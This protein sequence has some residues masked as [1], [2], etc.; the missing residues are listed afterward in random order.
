[1]RSVKRILAVYL[2]FA[3]AFQLFAPTT[4]AL[5]EELNV[6]SGATAQQP[7]GSEGADGSGGG[8]SADAGAASGDDASASDDVSAG[9]S[10][11]ASDDAASGDAAAGDAS[12]SQEPAA[13]E[14]A[15]AGDDAAD[16][17][18]APAMVAAG[19]TIATVD[20]LRAAMGKHGDVTATGGTV[21]A[22]TFNDAVGLRIISN[23]DPQLYQTAALTKGG[24]SGDALDLSSNVNYVFYGLGSEDYPFKGSFDTK[25]TSIALAT[26]LFNNVELNPNIRIPNLIWKGK[27][28]EPVIAANVE[29]GGQD[30][31]VTIQIADSVSGSETTAGITSALLGTVSGQLSLSATYSFWGTRKGLGATSDATGNVGLLANTVASGEFTVRSVDFSNQMVSG[32]TVKATNGNAGLLV[33]AVNDGAFLHVGSLSNVPTATVQSSKG[34]AGGVVGKVGSS[35]GATVEVTSAIDISNLT[36]KGTA[37]AGGFIGQATKLTLGTENKKVTCP[38]TVGGKVEDKDGNKDEDK[39]SGNVGGFIGEVSFGS[40][41]EFTCNDQI[42]TGDGVTLAG[43]ADESKGVGAAIGKLNFDNP[44]ATVSFNGGTF[45]STYGN[46]GAAAVY[47]GLV[48]SVTGCANS[49]PLRIESVT[50]KFAL[51]ATPNFTGGFVGWLGR[52]TGATLEVKNATVNC[53]QLRQ[54][55]KGFGGVAGCIDNKSIADINGVTV[56]NEGAIE[57]G[58]GIA[59]ES[60]GSAIRLGGV[61]DFSGMKFDPDNSFVG[62]KVISQ[63]ANVSAGNPTLVFACGTGSDS[64]PSDANNNGD[65]WVY[66]RCPQTKIDDLGSDQNADCGY[67]EVIRLDDKKLPKNLIQ[68]NMNKHEL[69]GPSTSD[70][71]WQVGYDTSNKW[72]D[73]NRTLNIKSAQDFVCL[74]LTVRFPSLWVGVYGFGGANGSVLLGSDVTINLKDNVD[75][76]GTGVGGLGFDSASNLQTFRGT[77]NGNGKTVTLAIGEPYGMRDNNDTT[78]GNG[79]IYRHNRLGLFAA[80]GDGA[81]ANEHTATVNNLTVD[82]SIKIDNGLGVDAGSLAATITGNATLNG[83]TCKPAITCDDTFGNDVNIGGVAGSVSGGGTIIFDSSNMSGSTKAQAT[84]NTGATLNGSTRIGGAVGYVADVAAIVNVVSLEVGGATASDNTIIASDSASGKIAQVGGFIGCIAQSTYDKKTGEIVSSAEKNVNITGLS[85]DSFNMTVGKNGDA[86]NGAG[87]LLGYSWGNAVVT[88]GDSSKNTNDS[89]YAL[90]TNSA[91]ITANSAGELGGLVYA[92]SGHWI[93]NDYAIDLSGTTINA[94]SATTLGLL[95]GRGSKVAAG[96]YGSE[97]YTGL[98]LEDMAYWETAYKVP[99]GEKAIVAPKVTIFDEWVGNGVKQGSKLMDGEWN[100]VVSLHTQADALDMTGEAEKDNSYKNRSAFGRSHNTNA[101]IRYYYNL[102]RAYDAMKN[103]GKN[104]TVA[105][106]SL[107]TPQELL[108]WSACRYAPADIQKYIAPGM[109]GNGNLVGLN[110]YTVYID[111]KAATDNTIDLKGYSY[112]PAQ[113]RGHVYIQNANIKFRYSDIKSEYVNNKSNATGTQHENMH[114]GLLRTINANLTVSNVTLGGTI[115]VAVN[116]GDNNSG[117]TVSGALVCRYIYGSS[118]SVKKISINDLKLDGL[119]VDGAAEKTYAPLLINEMQTYVNL[120]AKNI[121]TTGYADNTK[122]ATS[123]F[124]KLGVGSAADQVTATFSLI[125]LPSA[126]DNTIF[127]HA[128][129]LESFGYGEGKTGSAVYTFVKADQDNK[130]VTF[131][132]EIDSKGEYSGKQLWYYDESTYGTAAGLVTVDGKKANADNP[133]FSGYLPYVYKG[134]AIESNVQYHEIKVNQRV[135]K[136]TTG[137]GTYGDPYAITKASE[138]NVIAEYINTQNATDGWEVTIARNQETLCQRRS[139]SEDT[140]NEVTYVYNQAKKIWEKKTGAGTTDPN[141]TLDDA[142]MHSYLQSAYYSIEPKNED[143]AAGTI[144]LDAASFQGLG[145]LGNPFRG[146]IVGDLA[147]EGQQATIAINNSTSFSKGLIPYSYGGVVKNLKVVYQSN[148]SGIS[149]AGKDSNG[150]PGSF[151]G[152]VI[153]CILGGD[154]IID[155]VSVSSRSGAAATVASAD[156]DPLIAAVADSL[157]SP[158]LVPIGGYV[159][160]VTGGGVIFRNS[161]NVGDALN[162]WHVAGASRY[163]NPY[164]GRVIDGYAFSELGDNRSL[165]NTDRNY[166]INNLNT[167]DTKCVETGATQGRY[168]GDANKNAENLA[169]TTT[170]KDSQGLLVLSAIISSGAAGGSANAKAPDKEH[171]TNYGTYAGSRA[172]SGGNTSNNTKYQ[173]GNQDFGK[174]RNAN[175]KT[176]GQP[177]SA[178]AVADFAVASNDDRLSPGSQD[179][180]ALDQ[181]DGGK[182][183]S[184]YLVAKYATWQT[185]NICAAQASGMDLQFANA[186]YDMTPYGT[187]YTGLSGRYYSN[188]CA[189]DKGAD[190]DR[191]VPLV[192]TINGNGATIKVGDKNG[193]AYDIKEYTDD[194]YK[195]TGVGA[196]F[197]TVAYT[198]TNV[199]GSVANNNDYTV[200]N[201]KFEYCNISLTYTNAAGATDGSGDAEI[202]VGLL[203]G[204]TANNSSLAN[205]GK[206]STITMTN[207]KV[208][209][210]NNVGGLL[211]SSGYGSRKTDK[212]DTTWMV[213]RNDTTKT[214]IRYSPVKLYNCS[215]SNMDI[216][217]VQNVGGFVGKLNSGS[218]GGVWTTGDMEIAKDS[219][220]TASSDNP[221]IGGVVGVSRDAIF[222]NADTTNKESTNGGKATIYGLTLTVAKNAST[223]SGVGGLV[224]R[225]ENSIFAYN[226]TV[227]GDEEKKKVFGQTETGTAKFKNVGGIAGYIT[228]NN[229]FKF[230]TC[231]V[232]NIDLESREV[233]GGISGNISGNASGSPVITCN[234]VVVS[235]MTFGSSYAGGINGSLGGTPAFNITNTVIKNNVF[236]NPSNT[237]ES[238]QGNNNG[239]SRSGGLS[240]D[241]RGVFKLSNV[242]FDCNDFQGKNGQGIFFG[243]TKIDVRVYAAGVDIKP[244]EGKTNSDLPPLMLDTTKDQSNAKKVNTVS[245]VAFGDYEDKLATPDSDNP[246]TLYSDDDAAGYTTTAASPYV[247]TSP[248]SDKIAVRVSDADTADRYLFGDGA[249]VDL[250][251]T[252]Q[253]Q[254]GKD[255]AGRYTYT[256]IGGRDDSGAYR[257]TNG[258]NATSA[259]SYNSE[260]SD[261]SKQVAT[262]FTVL[263]IP[264]Q[265]TTTVTNYLNLVTNGGFSDAVRLNGDSGK[266]YVTAKAEK[267]ELKQKGNDKVFVK[268][269][270]PASLS[271][272]G[273]GT[274][275]MQFR[276][277]SNWDNDKGQF[278]LLSVTFN[279]GAGHTYKVQVP[280]VVKR[281]FEVNFAATY[282]YGTNFKADDYSSKNAHV[283][284]GVGDAMTGYLTWTYNKARATETEYGWKTY[285][286]GGGSMK[287]PNKTLLFGGDG[288]RGTLPAGTQLTLVDT[289]NNNKEYHYT[290]G[291]DGA[292]SV[293]LTDFAYSDGSDVKHYYEEQWLSE[294]MGV[295]ASSNP[296]SGAWVKL[297]RN[298]DTTKAGVRIKTSVD[299]PDADALGYVYYRPWASGDTGDR[300]DLALEGGSEPHPSESFFL[301]VRVPNKDSAATV[302]GYTGTSLSSGVNTRINYVKRSNESETDSHDNTASTYS[303][304]SGYNQTLIDNRQNADGTEGTQV[305]SVDTANSFTMDVTDTV[306]CGNNEYNSSDTLYY[307]LNSSLASYSGSALT[308]ASGYPSGTSGTYSFYV[309]VG[310]TYYKPSKSAD[311]AGNVKWSWEPAG[312]GKAAVSGKPWSADGGDMQLVLSDSEGTPIDLSGIREIARG[313]TNAM[314]VKPSFS[315]QMKADLQM[316][317]P[318]CQNAI[319]ASEDASAYTKPTYRSFLSPHADTLSTSTMAKDNEGKMRYYRKGG[320]ASTIALTATKK[321]QLGINV[322]DL[323][324]ADGTI[325][326]AATY[327]LSKLSG[328][329]EKLGKA[330]KATFTLTLQKREKDGS[331]KDVSDI[332]GYLSVQQCAQLGM[333]NVGVSDDRNSIVFTDAASN[334]VLATRDGSSPI[335]RLSF[336]VKVNTDVESAQHFYANYRLVMTAHLSGSGVDDTP[337]NASGSIAGYANSDYVTYT[338]TRVHMEGIGHG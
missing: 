43:K 91:S 18:D 172:Y 193:V 200:Q 258:Y 8:S 233:S 144:E 229:E 27:G 111:G 46:G 275:S 188:A 254:A 6:V 72:S 154:N 133:Q 23:A 308:G 59:A 30:L 3:M 130:K 182:V 49:K 104:Y 295:K 121:S 73:K 65:Y 31:T 114:C 41:I 288:E 266:Q 284:T 326:L 319:A 291:P 264:G 119:T 97:S 122:A 44:T 166:K 39:D 274:N 174:V 1:M 219:T 125:N 112:Y 28:S 45:K 280:I 103:N 120:N 93:I 262:D 301:V 10:E 137:C 228:S 306:D 142:T 209:G 221:M 159:G 194:D 267:F 202:G 305:M 163:D 123:L 259:Q 55:S 131:G 318:A 207:C 15:S 143:G 129:L 79:K 96:V 304:A 58:A 201:L 240:G 19:A 227:T 328:A 90:K 161:S 101:N 338:L 24:Q 124:G 286:Q 310:G 146:V 223:S 149:Y 61:T 226:L 214:D 206:Y 40:P 252:I 77:F 271:V 26:S 82:G 215:Y 322:D 135:P 337:V 35:A 205:Y 246:K 222:V 290:V 147:N 323:G 334:S 118:S 294:L 169:I 282:T 312:E 139:S 189:S 87:G 329:D 180:G 66:K 67:G 33:G 331:Y 333:D 107:S 216:S 99:S 153:G 150:V 11:A 38:K 12:E 187:G 298:E 263:E 179:V 173:F 160:A 141:D 145:N 311:S 168:R 199:R 231:E 279:D 60:W 332:G 134:K 197:T 105:P 299:D 234:N 317:G 115:G 320:G 289:A 260:N 307:Q 203:A 313:A 208:G 272:V 34:C 152:G 250:A 14:S 21:T 32:G 325:A 285:L 158:H 117:G 261:A 4:D 89:T 47:G 84:I 247:T 75:L 257:N 17:Q 170:V 300:Y 155:G 278:T 210:S 68:I 195:L 140:G 78:D 192:A 83:V 29:G 74:A 113:P 76:S 151:F 165:K 265:D 225:A 212:N 181:T 218:Q 296:S 239:K 7:G 336:V 243:D 167:G 330:E 244:G 190:R 276:A 253:D 2:T 138:L 309:K 148:V 86:K 106:V 53:T 292:A 293:A 25:G 191:I 128:S 248:V 108:L 281:L 98:Y 213:N 277:S 184:P 37:A 302:N 54:S 5:A 238:S 116:D 50:T 217:G 156:A 162:I 315:I 269:S 256:N 232:S 171:A 136:L 235:G 80:I 220:I 9:G 287:S 109:T 211:G 178:D 42:D 327:D 70:W 51:E 224:G 52:G 22:I 85:F 177:S 57:N 62:K 94:E 157:T 100:T 316:S 268:S 71:S 81:T 198:S 324:T 36:V 63:I 249:N 314:G 176:V 164:V 273:N 335:L 102:D 230:D 69:E 64:V 242:L 283:L 245:Y 251:S 48:G 13:D 185:G 110:S 186:T 196:L 241:G 20:E 56:K 183:N 175:Y 95:V 297:K 204:T 236:K 237:W 132:N 88:I 270:D 321:T 92:A 303:V 127:T 255:V 126:K 16:A